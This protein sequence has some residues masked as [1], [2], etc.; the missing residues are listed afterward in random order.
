MVWV[1]T[2]IIFITGISSCTSKRTGNPR[3]LVFAKTAFYHK[4]IPAGLAAIQQLGREN[5]F[6]VDTTT[7]A[8]YF[9]EDSLKN[10]SAVIFL[11]TTGDVLNHYQQAAFER[12][13]QAGGGFTG[14]HSASDTE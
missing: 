14:I 12:F 13:I 9:N 8:A 2:V 4:S 11:N 5:G 1:L 3:V 6:S 7:N 10:Y